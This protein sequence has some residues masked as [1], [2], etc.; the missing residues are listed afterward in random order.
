M[1]ASVAELGY[2][3]RLVPHPNGSLLP[4]AADGAA[5]RPPELAVVIGDEALCDRLRDEDAFTDVPILLSVKPEELNGR[6]PLSEELLIAPFTPAELEARIVR[7][8][9]QVGGGTEAQSIRVGS[10][11]VDL[12]TYQVAVGGEPVDFAFKEYELLRFLIT[13]PDRV[14]S[15]EALLNR[16][17]GYDYYGGARTVDVHVRRLRAKLGSEH[18][19]RIQTVRGVGYRFDR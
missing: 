15:R 18:A 10:L 13:H 4:N 11:E 16:V 19:A 8:R 17:W 5:A 7:A 14:F 9:Q 3:P 1:A 12:V 2:T 6:V